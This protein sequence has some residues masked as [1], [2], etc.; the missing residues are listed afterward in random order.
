MLDSDDNNIF[1]T[2][3]STQTSGLL[4]IS[5]HCCPWTF[6]KLSYLLMRFRPLR[7]DSPFLEDPNSYWSGNFAGL[8]TRGCPLPQVTFACFKAT[9]TMINYVLSLIYLFIC[10]EAKMM[11]RASRALDGKRHA[12]LWQHIVREYLLDSTLHSSDK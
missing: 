11:R 6:T 3:G 4:S 9:V 2:V 12:C 1:Y 10:L 8:M 5:E 7:W